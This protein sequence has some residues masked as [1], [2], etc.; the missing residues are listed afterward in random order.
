MAHEVLLINIIYSSHFYESKF[1][2]NLTFKLLQYLSSKIEP[3]ITLIMY[4]DYNY[5]KILWYFIAIKFF[6]QL[7]DTQQKSLDT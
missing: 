5:L 3:F 2:K 6:Q 4:N 1:L 7:S